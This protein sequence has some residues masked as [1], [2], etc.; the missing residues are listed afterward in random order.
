MNPINVVRLM[1]WGL[2]SSSSP[3]TL[4]PVV[5]GVVLLWRMR[6]FSVSGCVIAVAV[7]AAAL[8]VR[9]HNDRQLCC[10]HEDHLEWHSPHLGLY[11]HSLTC[12]AHGRVR[13]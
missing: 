9:A 13:R 11:E 10:E 4:L 7:A 2:T 6:S 5:F 12:L 3:E 1:S 8:V